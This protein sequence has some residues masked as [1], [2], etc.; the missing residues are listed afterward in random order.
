MK[1]FARRTGALVLG[2][3]LLAAAPAAAQELPPAGQLVQ[4]YVEAVGGRDALLAPQSTRTRGTFQI[5]AAGLGG[6]L[7]AVTARPGR[8]ATHVT[9]PGLGVIRSGF[10]GTHGWS[11]D[12]MTG[13]RL[14]SGA[15]LETMRESANPLMMVRDPSLFRTMETVERTEM[16][17]EPCYRVR[18]VTLAGRE[19]SD[20]YHVETGLLVAQVAT[21]ESPMGSTVVTTYMSEYRP[22]GGVLMPTKLV[23]DLGM[24]QQNITITGVEFDVVEEADLAPPAE[25]HAL[26]GH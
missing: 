14:L 21:Q 15:E 13:A 8:M 23:Q 10:D 26:M 12:P 22:F 19:G 4:R 24:M 18:T 1:I 20:C 16:A 9:I 11:L 3:V 7:V 25:I 17:G 2:A 5:P 6:E